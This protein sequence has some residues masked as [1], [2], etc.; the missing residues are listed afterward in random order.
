[1]DKEDIRSEMKDFLEKTGKKPEIQVKE[2]KKFVNSKKEKHAEY[3]EGQLQMRGINKEI[4]DYVHKRIL[5]EGEQVPT[6]IEHG[7]GD[8]DYNI[9]SRRL[10]HKIGIELKNKF[11]GT[12]KESAQLF[13]RNHLTSKNVYRLNVLYKTHDVEKG[14][15][16]SVD[17]LQE[18][19]KVTGYSGEK[20]IVEGL[21]SKKKNHISIDQVKKRI[22]KIKSKVVQL[23]PEPHVMDENFQPVP[24]VSDKE[25]VEGQNVKIVEFEGKY[26][27]A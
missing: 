21:V 15:V 26:Y 18:P 1:M 12:V 3:F 11:G 6:V 19:Y 4:L 22:D 5:N 14:Q 24:I 2:K 25:L 20:L 16:I 17:E 13:S 8:L 7:R 9:S 23:F 10:I 27:L